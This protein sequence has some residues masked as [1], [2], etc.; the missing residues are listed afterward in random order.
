MAKLEP[1]VPGFYLWSYMPSIPAAVIFLILFLG[2]TGIHTVKLIRSRAWFNI[3]LAIG[4]VF[5]IIGFIARIF[6]HFHTADL[7]PFAIQSVFILI[8]PVLFAASVYMALGRIIRSV[9]AEQ[10]SIVP[11]RWVTKLFV[12]SDVVAFFVQSSGAGLQAVQSM[13]TISKVIVII[14][15]IVQ[16]GMFVFF[17]VVSL[18]PW[19]YHMYTLFAVS[20]L[21]LVRSI[22][23]VVEYA[24]GYNGYLLTHEWPLYVFDCV[25]MWLVMVIWAVRYPGD[26]RIGKPEMELIATRSDDDTTV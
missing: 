5:E 12:T 14:G 16:V 9:N 25:L 15:L 19:K 4:G 3:P 11:L 22:Y 21:I 18:S 20:I 26:I 13:Q 23:R 7:P 24:M 8:A 2:A 1:Y 17:I 10:H 6:S